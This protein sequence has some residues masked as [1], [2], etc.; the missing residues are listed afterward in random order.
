MDAADAT[1]NDVREKV[2]VSEWQE[3]IRSG[4]T[5][6]TAVSESQHFLG[7]KYF[8]TRKS[9]QPKK[10][11]PLHTNYECTKCDR[12]FTIVGEANR[13]E[14]Y[15]HINPENPNLGHKCVPIE[16]DQGKL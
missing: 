6:Y 16:A 12:T 10:A 9:Y 7:H 2:F 13:P 3:K 8:Y 1:A 4:K 5:N 15:F 14:A 11:P